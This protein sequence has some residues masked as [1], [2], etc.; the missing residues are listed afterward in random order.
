MG[1]VSNLS[2]WDRGV[3]KVSRTSAEN[4]PGVGFEFDTL[5]R[6]GQPDNGRMSYRVA[7]VTDHQCRVQLT[8]SGGNAR[9]FKS[10]QWTF[11]AEPSPEGTLLTCAT[12]FT[13]RSFYIIVAPVFYAMKYAIRS[14]LENLKRVLENN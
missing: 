3:A 14:D 10:A 11:R 7:E 4:A 2:K 12:D 13:L 8:S 1:D 5:A 9:F 6:S